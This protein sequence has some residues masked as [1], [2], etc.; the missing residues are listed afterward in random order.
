MTDK[1]YPRGKIKK[2]EVEMFNLKLKSRA[3]LRNMLVVCPMEMDIRQKDK[4]SSKK[5][6]NRARNGKAWKRQSQSQPWKSQR[7][8]QKSTPKNT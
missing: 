6:Q 8:N 4:K 2:L 3:R 7:S 1:Y 5:G